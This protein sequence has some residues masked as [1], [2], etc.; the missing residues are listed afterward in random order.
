MVLLKPL[1]PVSCE[2]VSGEP[3]SMGPR[4]GSLLND[5]TR[6]RLWVHTREVCSMTAHGRL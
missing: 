3:E 4:Y 5:C 1:L 6:L 2:V